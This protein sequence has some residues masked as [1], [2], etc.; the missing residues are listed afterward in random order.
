MVRGLMSDVA[1][2]FFAPTVIDAG[3]RRGRRARDHRLVLDGVFWIAWTGSPRGVLLE[4]G[5]CCWRP[6][7]TA[8][9]ASYL[10]FILVPSAHLRV[11]HVV[12]R[13]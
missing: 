4:V 11:R 5:L 8:A 10:S 3:P 1:W 9:R 13:P 12:D 2:A 7:T 6:S